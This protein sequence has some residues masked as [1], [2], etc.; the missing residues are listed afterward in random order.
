M[1]PILS[2]AELT[3]LQYLHEHTPVRG[4]RIALDPKA[5]KRDL[6]ISTTH[7]ADDS[8]TLA[9]HGFAGVRHARVGDNDASPPV[10]SAIWVTNK[11]VDYL[12]QSQSGRGVGRVLG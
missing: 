4:N 12:K 3:L 8:S 9:T 1:P 2:P 7:L 10:C 6:R 5:I 11:G